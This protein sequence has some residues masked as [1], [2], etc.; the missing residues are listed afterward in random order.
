MSTS[1]SSTILC[2]TSSA[3]AATPSG[4]EPVEASRRRPIAAG[5]SNERNDRPLTEGRS[6]CCCSGWGSQKQPEEHPGRS[7]FGTDGCWVEW[8][9]ACASQSLQFV[10]GSRYLALFL[11][12][13]RVRQGRG[14]RLVKFAAATLKPPSARTRAVKRQV[15][16]S[17]LSS[18]SRSGKGSQLH[19]IGIKRCR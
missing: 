7:D 8:L 5:N 1:R 19:A 3:D 18:R 4:P 10:S 2:F 9:P 16:V 11:A 13:A 14:E 6:S 12:Q 15:R 17:H